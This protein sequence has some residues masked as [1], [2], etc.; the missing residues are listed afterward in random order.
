MD[1]IPT[2]TQQSALDENHL[3]L[4]PVEALI[5]YR[6]PKLVQTAAYIFH[7]HSSL[8]MTSSPPQSL[9][10]IKSFLLHFRVQSLSSSVTLIFCF[11]FLLFFVS[12]FSLTPLSCLSYCFPSFPFYILK[13]VE[14]LV[15]DANCQTLGWSVKQK[16]KPALLIPLR[17]QGERLPIHI[18]RWGM[19]MCVFV[20]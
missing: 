2:Q 4:H 15:G 6:H 18:I 12:L 10:C 17:S 9:P 19:C 3:R 16:K 5:S 13:D 1:V 20:V 7:R 8:M 11:L 14:V